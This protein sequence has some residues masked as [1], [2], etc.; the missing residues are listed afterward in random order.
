[1]QII[2][3]PKFCIVGGTSH[4][5]M[6]VSSNVCTVKGVVLCYIVDLCT[7]QLDGTLFL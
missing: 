3:S 6:F 1:M 7:G 2:I 5:I 4:V